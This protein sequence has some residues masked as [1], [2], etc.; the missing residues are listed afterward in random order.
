MNNSAGVFWLNSAETWVDVDTP[1]QLVSNANV[2]EKIVNLVAGGA[3]SSTDSGVNVY[4]MSETGIVDVFFML[5]P[6]IYDVMRQYSRLTGT[7]PL[8]PVSFKPRCNENRIQ[9]FTERN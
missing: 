1:T 8:P 3:S 5:G 7:A 4:F 6:G 2:M 9:V